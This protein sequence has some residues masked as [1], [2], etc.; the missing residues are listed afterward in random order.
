MACMMACSVSLSSAQTVLA[1]VAFAQL[2]ASYFCNGVGLVGGL[3][4]AGEQG[5]FRHGLRSELGVNVAGAQEQELLYTVPESFFN[6]V[7]LDHQ[8]LVDELGRV[9]V[10][11][12]DAADFGGSQVHLGGLFLGKESLHGGLVGEV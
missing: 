5:V 7:G 12:V 8:V 2:D 1:V 9:G 4:G 11:G 6:D 10:V 3:Q